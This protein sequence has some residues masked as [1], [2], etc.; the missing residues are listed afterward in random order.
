MSKRTGYVWW[1]TSFGFL[2]SKQA[3]IAGFP[4]ICTCEINH[5]SNVYTDGI[6]FSEYVFCMR[7]YSN[8]FK[9]SVG[10]DSMEV[11]DK[12]LI[13]KKLIKYFRHQTKENIF[14]KLFMNF[15][16]NSSIIFRMPANALG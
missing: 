10:N 16:T 5:T 12:S 7:K 8:F 9:P 6:V 4:R 1:F 14:N 3:S 11:L 13:I 15:Y 2:C